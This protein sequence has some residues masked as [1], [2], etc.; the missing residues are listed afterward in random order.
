MNRTK[1]RNSDS[2]LREYLGY[3]TPTVIGAVAHTVYCLADVFFVSKGVGALGLAALNIALPVFT[4]Y[5]TFSLLIGVGA[6]TTISVCRGAGAYDEADRSF[7]LAIAAIL[8]TGALITVGG[9]VF[10][11]PFCRLMGANDELLPYMM[12]YLYPVNMVAFTYL[13][14]SMLVVLVRSDGA[15]KLVMAASTIGNLCN[16]ALDYWMVSILHWGMFGAGLATAIGPCVSLFI[17]LLHFYWK[18]NQVRLARHFFSFGRLARIVRN[19]IGSSILELSAGMIIVLFNIALLNVAGAD[20]VAVFSI[21]SNIGYVG[22]GIFN[23]MAQAAQPI[24]SGSYGA[25]DFSR[26]QRANR[27]ALAAAALFSGVTYLFILLFPRFLITLFISADERILALGIPALKLY[28][29]SFLFTAVN[30]IFMYYFQSVEKAGYT[31]ALSL[32]RGIVLV[33][34]GL[35]ILPR[36]FGVDGIWLTLPF[37]EILA[38]LAFFPLLAPF[39]RKLRESMGQYRKTGGLQT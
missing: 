20:G 28:F 21:I 30:T 14:S 35:L 11:E 23:G 39:E 16:V 32:L 36:F 27:C 5:T 24:I 25:G 29:I 33:L 8:F 31:M 22:K 17:L 10:L 13:L 1:C 4:I 7:T 15:P 26:L 37:A 12:D 34:A 3:L 38:F 18:N 2:V 19:G 6:A 9:T